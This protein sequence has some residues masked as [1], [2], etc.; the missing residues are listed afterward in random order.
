ML[1]HNAHGYMELDSDNSAYTT[2]STLSR[3]CA[4]YVGYDSSGVRYRVFIHLIALCTLTTCYRAVP[5]SL[6]SMPVVAAGW[7]VLGNAIGALWQ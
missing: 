2:Y 3:N 4:C 7:D 5:F 6:M 1:S